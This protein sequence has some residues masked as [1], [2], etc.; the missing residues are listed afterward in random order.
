MVVVGNVLV[1]SLPDYVL[2][3]MG[4]SYT[5]VSTLFASKMNKEHEPLRYELTVSQP[6]NKGMICSIVYRDCSVYID[7]LYLHI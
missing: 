1:C 7:D 4:S 2:F 6:T 5:F 3:D